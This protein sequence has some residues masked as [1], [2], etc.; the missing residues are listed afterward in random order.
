MELATALCDATR[1]LV[2]Y[3]QRSA[4]VS[5]AGVGSPVVFY[6]LLLLLVFLKLAFLA[7]PVDGVAH[8]VLVPKG[9]AAAIGDGPP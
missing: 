5:L 3:S 1:R 9:R 8:G 6:R 7:L 2:E 4:A